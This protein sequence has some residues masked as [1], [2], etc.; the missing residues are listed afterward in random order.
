LDLRKCVKSKKMFLSVQ[1][2]QQFYH[3]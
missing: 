3:S 2:Q 1:Q